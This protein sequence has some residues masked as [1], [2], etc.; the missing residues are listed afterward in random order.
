MGNALST[1]FGSSSGTV[2]RN[3]YVP[4]YLYM[5]LPTTIDDSIYRN[6][7][8]KETFK[9]YYKQ[10]GNQWVL[11]SQVPLAQRGQFW[12]M[13]EDAGLDASNAD[14][15]AGRKLSPVTLE[16]AL[17]PV[18]RN[19][20]ELIDVR[21]VSSSGSSEIDEAVVYGF[22]QSTFYNKTGVAV[23]GRFTYEF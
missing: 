14:F 9:A 6:V 20:V 23:G 17:G 15:K 1:T 19:R 2:G 11:K 13:L 12:K 8:T 18:N 22:K 16:F 5:P 7:P 3:M 10:S 21:I 4:I